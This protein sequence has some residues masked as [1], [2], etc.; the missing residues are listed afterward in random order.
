MFDLKT[1]LGEYWP[2]GVPLLVA[3]K[4]DRICLGYSRLMA[5]MAMMREKGLAGLKAL[6]K[7]A[8]RVALSEALVFH[9]RAYER[10]DDDFRHH[11]PVVIPDSDLARALGDYCCSGQVTIVPEED[12][13]ELVVYLH[14]MSQDRP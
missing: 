8:A 2:L 10:F 1:E 11:R 12:K 14:A 3:W 6:A 5:T 13:W 4:S 7:E 9:N